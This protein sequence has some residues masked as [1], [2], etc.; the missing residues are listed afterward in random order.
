MARIAPRILSVFMAS[1]IGCGEGPQGPET[2]EVAGLV[3][4][5]G[6]PLGGA[7][8]FFHPVNAEGPA[9]ACQTVTGPDGR[10]TVRTHVG[11]GQ[12]KPGM[13]P[14]EDRVAVS[15]LD[16]ANVTSTLTPPKHTLPENYASPETSGFTATVAAGKEN[17]F[18]F[19]LEQGG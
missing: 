1:C 7:D 11:A 4:M 2:V 13:I 10:F 19:G 6:K 16:A 5:N 18:T 17:D 12:Y 15:K 9:Q 3:T 14:G 8:V